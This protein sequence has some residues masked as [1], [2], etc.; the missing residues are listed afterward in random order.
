MVPLDYALAVVALTAPAGVA[1]GHPHLGPAV[2]QLACCW[3]LL[4]PREQASRPM[5]RSSYAANLA[6]LRQRYLDLHDTPSLG[7]IYRLPPLRVVEEHLAFNRAFRKTLQQRAC[8]HPP[9][10]ARDLLHRHLN[11][12]D[13]RHRLWDLMRDAHVECYY[14]TARRRTLCQLR[15]ALGPDAYDRC[16]WPTVV[17]LEAFT[18]R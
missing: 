3:E 7:D 1:D 18:E 8:A 16:D 2:Q 5:Q 10:P 11:E 17:P 12:T 15:Q 6:W 14:L 9:G 4:D 13:R